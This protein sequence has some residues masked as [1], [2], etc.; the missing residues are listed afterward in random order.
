MNSKPIL[1][2]ENLNIEFGGNKII[3]DLSFEVKEKDILAIIGPNGAGKTV[4]FRALLGLIPY[5]GKIE[6]KKAVRIGYVPQ[7]FSIEPNL[8]LLVKEFLEYKGR[9]REI[10][11]VLEAVGLKNDKRFINSPLGSL[12]GG[13]LQRILIAFALLGDPDILLFDEPT[14][15]IDIGSEETIY[16]LLH[17]LRDERGLTI[18]LISHDIH[19]VYHYALNVLCLNKEMLCFGPPRQSLND[20]IL[21]MLYG[22]YAHHQEKS[23]NKIEK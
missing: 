2:V 7:K 23:L 12:S 19:I 10:T 14:A 16:N 6:W 22:K 20:K 8:P 21:K 11:K 13:E 18:I 4:L 15:G 5:Q 17:R 3:K 9:G 1:K